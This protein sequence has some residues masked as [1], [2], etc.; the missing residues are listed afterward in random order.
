MASGFVQHPMLQFIEEKIT[1]EKE[2]T[3]ST[4]SG[5]VSVAA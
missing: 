4:L 1:N 3:K 2:H 5:A